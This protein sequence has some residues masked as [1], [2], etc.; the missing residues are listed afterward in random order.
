MK[1][2]LTKQQLE[3]DHVAAGIAKW[4][5]AERT[6]LEKQARAKSRE[7]LRVEYDLRHANDE[8]A[9]QRVLDESMAR[10]RAAGA[11]DIYPEYGLEAN[12]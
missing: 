12:T 8:G 2:E 4:G 7:T 1:T 9:N 3:A 5:E 10:Q 6:G 11:L